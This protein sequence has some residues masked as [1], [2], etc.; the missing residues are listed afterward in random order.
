M[1]YK[2]WIP[3]ILHF[4]FFFLSILSFTFLT[5][6]LC[7]LIYLIFHVK[8]KIHLKDGNFYCTVKQFWLE[9]AIGSI[10]IGYLQKL[11]IME[12]II[13]HLMTTDTGTN[14]YL[15]NL[16]GNFVVPLN[17]F[18][19]VFFLTKQFWNS[20]LSDFELYIISFVIN[21]H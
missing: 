17:N 6:G 20:W 18:G 7:I 10:S 13:T 4:F 2:R 21:F 8:C 1:L 5:I 16:F 3:L 12:R 11:S 15:Q 9:L 19:I 14:N